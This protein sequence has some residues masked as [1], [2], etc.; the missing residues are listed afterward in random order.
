MSAFSIY[1][2]REVSSSTI[3]IPDS[4]TALVKLKNAN[5]RPPAAPVPAWLALIFVHFF[6]ASAAY[7]SSHLSICIIIEG[8]A[9]FCGPNTALHPS[10]PQR[11]FVTSQAT[12]N[13]HSASSGS[14]Y[15]SVISSSTSSPLAP[16]GTCF[17]SLSRKPYP[18]A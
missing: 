10:S 3:L 7:F 16:K 13:S 14:T 2:S 1:F 18:N 9:P 11:I 15:V 4:R 17:P 8:V 5:P 6:S 12:R